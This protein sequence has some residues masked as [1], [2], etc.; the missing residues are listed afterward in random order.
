MKTLIAICFALALL[1]VGT[2]LAQDTMNNDSMKAD[3]PQKTLDVKG[4]I[5]DDGKMFNAV[6]GRPA[7]S[8]GP[9]GKLW[10]ATAESGTLG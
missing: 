4:K 6:V 8:A 9:R 3:A 7:P 5:S 2:V 1:N 10:L